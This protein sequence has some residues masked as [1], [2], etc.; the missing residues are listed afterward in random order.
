VRTTHAP[1]LY[2]LCAAL[3]AC[4][5]TA[6]APPEVRLPPYAE[7]AQHDERVQAGA[8]AIPPGAPIGGGGETSCG[9]AEGLAAPGLGG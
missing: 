4:R 3:C 9:C 6:G 2:A 7:G 1:L 5:S 8:L